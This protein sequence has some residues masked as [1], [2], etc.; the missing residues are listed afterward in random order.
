M[1]W[2]LANESD[3]IRQPITISFAD[4]DFSRQRIHR[5][6]QPIFDEDVVPRERLQEAR[7]P[8]V[9][10]ADERGRRQIAPALALIGAM[11]GD[12]FEPLLDHGDLG[13]N[14]AAVR[15]ELGFTGSAEPDPAADT[16]QVRPH[17]RQPRQQILE[18]RK[19]HLELGLAATRPCREDVEND[20]GAVHHPHPDMLLEL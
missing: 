15:L 8:G 16:R 11:L 10:V 6:K 3:C 1:V 5:R 14:P 20:L 2:Q 12:V 18:L 13:A 4:I 19:L 9:R 7:L 17:A